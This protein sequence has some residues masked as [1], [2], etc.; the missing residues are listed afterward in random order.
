MSRKLVIM[1][2]QEGREA[3]RN[4]GVLPPSF[5]K[6]FEEIDEA[7]DWRT[8]KKNESKDEAAS[9]S[10]STMASPLGYYVWPYEPDYA[11]RSP[12]YVDFP[13]LS[14]LGMPQPKT[15]IEYLERKIAYTKLLGSTI[16]HVALL[17]KW[18]PNAKVKQ[19]IEE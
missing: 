8:A 4:C 7:E 17:D 16:L 1:T 13:I 3:L 2:S 14:M 5:F 15:N 10:L 12:L 11:C 6:A 19:P 18:D 9:E